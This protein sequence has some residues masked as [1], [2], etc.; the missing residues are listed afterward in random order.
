MILSTPIEKIPNVGLA[1]RKRLKKIGIK[2]IRDLL[3]HLPHR[4]ED[5]SNI[6]RISEIKLNEPCC[7]QGKILEINNS[8]TWKKRMTL[9]HAVVSDKTAAPEP[10]QGSVRGAAIKVVWFN[11]PYLVRVIKPG[12]WVCLAG[13]AVIGKEGLYLSNPTY[14]KIFRTTRP[15]RG[16]PLATPEAAGHKLQTT[17]LVHTG[18]IVPVYPE[19]EGLSSRWLRFIIKPL[20]GSLKNTIPE[21]LPERI[22]K[23]HNLLDL[24]IAL[25]QVH[26]PDSIALAEKAKQRFSFEELFLIE[27]L[28]IKERIKLTQ[29]KAYQISLNLPLIKKFVASLSFKLTNT[30]RKSAWQILKDLEKPRPM[31]RLLEGDVGSGKTVVATMAALNVMKAGYQVG[32]MAPTEILT[33]QHFQEVSRFLRN[34]NL[35][36][37]LLTGKEDKFISKKLKNDTIEISRQKILEKTAKGE[38]DLLIGTHTLIQDK[39]KFKNLALVVLD[40]QHRFGVEQRAKLCKNQKKQEKIIPHLL[41]MT[42]T[43]IPRTLALT[44][45]GDLDLSL[46]TELPKGR[47]KIITKVIKP[48]ERKKI[49]NFIEKEVKKGRQ[50]FV[51]CPRIEPPAASQENKLD[52]TNY[53]KSGGRLSWAEV[54]AV[55]EEYE[56]LSKT[57]FPNLKVEQLYGKMTPKEKEKIMKDFKDKKTDILISTSVIEVGIDVPNATIMMIEGTERFGLAQLHQFRGR[58]GRSKLQSFCFLFTDSP[59]KKTQQRLKALLDSEDGFKLAEKDLEIRGPGDFSGTRQ[60]GIPD[61][62]MSSLKDISLVEKTRQAAKEILEQDPALKK[63]PL[64]QKRVEELREKV[65]LE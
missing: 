9:T 61:L 62:V 25:W 47:K 46:I 43:P 48:K 4:Y 1:Y 11:Q 23:K 13:R 17:N 40:E 64:L 20:L 19:T 33:K 14:E 59:A 58:V 42:A 28:V 57:I 15:W 5:F 8:S 53:I 26:F 31:N 3:F 44:I 10:K 21:T 27:L 29:K 6:I 63:Y 52:Q 65:H 32:F 35:N 51:V 30:Q 24:K 2:T 45:Y 7:I 34:F 49:Y 37:G 12:D 60:W 54:K 50:A 55:K 16:S 38:I 41:S 18:R 36:I 39:V 56:K 22:R